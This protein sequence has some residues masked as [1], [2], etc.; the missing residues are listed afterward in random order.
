MNVDHSGNHLGCHLAFNRAYQRYERS[1]IND[2]F[3]LALAVEDGQREP[4]QTVCEFSHTPRI[5]APSRRL[6][7]RE[8]GLGRGMV[9]GE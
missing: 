5:V 3:D 7:F 4:H 8:K 2:E 6:D 1:T 9:K